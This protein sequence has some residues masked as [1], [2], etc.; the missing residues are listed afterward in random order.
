M[1]DSTDTPDSV[2]NPTAA[3][4]RHTDREQKAD[5]TTLIDQYIKLRNRKWRGSTF[6]NAAKEPGSSARHL[7]DVRGL[8]SGETL[9]PS[10]TWLDGGGRRQS[11]VSR[12]WSR[13]REEHVAAFVSRP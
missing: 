7:L 2:M 8:G 12:P 4:G 10:G 13:D 3:E 6:G 11:L 5:Q 1:L 9:R